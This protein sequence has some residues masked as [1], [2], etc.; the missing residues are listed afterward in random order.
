[1]THIKKCFFV[2][3]LISE[4]VCELNLLTAIEHG[5]QQGGLACARGSYNQNVLGLRLISQVSNL[6]LRAR[7]QIEGSRPLTIAFKCLNIDRA[8][9]LFVRVI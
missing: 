7:V 6:P 3:T 8:R 2:D 1:M 4:G 9:S 5:V